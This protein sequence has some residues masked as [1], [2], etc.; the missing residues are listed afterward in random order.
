MFL[1]DANILIYAAVPTMVQH[2]AARHWL[3]DKLAGTAQT[4]GLPW[5]SLVAYLRITTNHR[6][7]APPASIA[8]AWRLATEWLQQAAT[9]VPGPGPRHQ[10]L[11]AEMIGTVRPVGDLIPDA[12]LAAL[13]VEHGLT[14]ASTDTDFARFSGVR[15]TNPLR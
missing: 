2:D 10:Y 9:W 5:S 7:F 15:W 11:L 12:H 13:A 14:I 6:I 3:D 8:D 4:V 1:V